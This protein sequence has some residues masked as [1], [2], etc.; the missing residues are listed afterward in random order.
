[1]RGLYLLPLMLQMGCV[2]EQ[3]IKIYLRIVDSGITEVVG[4]DLEVGDEP[5][6]DPNQ[7][8]SPTNEP[9]GDPN[10]GDP[11][12]GEPVGQPGGDPEPSGEASGEPSGEPGSD[13]GNGGGGTPGVF[14]ACDAAV[15]CI[16][17]EEDSSNFNGFFNEQ[18]ECTSASSD[19]TYNDWFTCVVDNKGEPCSGAGGGDWSGCD[20]SAVQ[21]CSD[22]N[23]SPL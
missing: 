16:L 17:A 8:G 9:S 20:C 22:N 1:M 3:P 7:S 4:G 18:Q 10:G 11:N 12:G 23:A 14:D 13:P 15:Y 19:S 6:D 21:T 5:F 2:V